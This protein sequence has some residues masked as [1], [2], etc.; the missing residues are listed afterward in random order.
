MPKWL[1]VTLGVLAVLLAIGGGA[2]WWLIMDGAAPDKVADFALDIGELR[3]LANEKPGDKPAEIRVE[4]VAA[5]AFPATAVVAGDGWKTVSMPVFTYQIAYPD[6]RTVI[7][8]TA[9]ERE[10]GG[11]N[12]ASFDPEAYAR[13]EKALGDASLILIT[14]EHMDHIGGLTAY[15]DVKAILPQ[16]RLTAE[17]LAHPERSVPAKFPDG[18]L[19][20]YEG[21]DYGHYEAIAPGIVLIKSPGHTPGSQMVYVQTADGREVLLIGDVAWHYKNIEVMRERARL[22]TKFMLKEN[23]DQVFSELKALGDLAETAP[24]I[25]IVPGHDG[26]VMARLLENGTLVPGFR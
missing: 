18:V 25:A 15:P 3:E 26:K 16:T 21:L 8:D 11:D 12:L 4:Q 23:R 22:V 10:M 14:H 17:Q 5:F 6:G 1:K 24:E 13:M 9:L 19:D 2:Y 20:G 7:V